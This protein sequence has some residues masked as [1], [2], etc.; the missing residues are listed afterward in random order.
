M[1][2]CLRHSRRPCSKASC[3]S[4]WL[5]A[6]IRSRLPLLRRLGPHQIR[7]QASLTFNSVGNQKTVAAALC[8]DAHD[9]ISLNTAPQGSP[10]AFRPG[11]MRTKR[12]V[13][14]GTN[15]QI[16]SCTG[17]G[18]ICRQCRGSRMFEGENRLMRFLRTGSNR[19]SV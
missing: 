13:N 1:L 18:E 3:S 10:R 12:L 2:L 8:Q 7:L 6:I 4:A 9:V 14:F 11:P 16:F 5:L 15:C 19:R 17:E